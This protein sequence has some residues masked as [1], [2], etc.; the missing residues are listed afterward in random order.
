FN[1]LCAPCFAAIGAIRREMNDAKW[2]LFAVAYQT[3]FAYSISLMIFNIGNL[4]IT[5]SFGPGTIVA[6]ALLAIFIYLLFR[7]QASSRA[8]QKAITSA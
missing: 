3:I 4:I 8:K 6:L 1:L 7:P 2:T 5:G